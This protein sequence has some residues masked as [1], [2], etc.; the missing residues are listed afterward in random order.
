MTRRLL[1]LPAAALA[2]AMAG[3]PKEEPATNATPAASPAASAMASPDASPAATGVSAMATPDAAATP[4]SGTGSATA[5]SGE[6]TITYRWSG[7]LSLYQYY[8]MTIRGT[9]TATVLFKVKPLRTEEKTVEDTL[10]AEEFATLKRL[11]AE[12]KFDDA[13]TEPRKIRVMDI[14]QTVIARESDGKKKEVIESPTQTVAAGY[15][16]RPLRKWFDDRVRT[17]LE[18]AGVAPRKGP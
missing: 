14:G 17:Y 2:L 15:E 10:T 8:E 11:F 9:D 12:T 18:K 4:G 13:T 3:C 7:G 5:T 1:L 6:Q 16:L